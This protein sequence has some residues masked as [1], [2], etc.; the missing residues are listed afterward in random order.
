MGVV[1]KAEDQPAAERFQHRH[2]PPRADRIPGA[3][4]AANSEEMIAAL[5]ALA[6]TGGT[7]ELDFGNPLNSS[8]L[9]WK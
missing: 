3:P 5:G 7:P 2:K 8:M 4:A 9:D 1:Y 6:F